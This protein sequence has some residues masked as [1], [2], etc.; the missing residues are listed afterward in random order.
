MKNYPD[1]Y[2]ESPRAFLRK[3]EEDIKGIEARLAK[4]D[5]LATGGIADL[6]TEYER[7]S[8]LV[9]QKAYGL[10]QVKDWQWTPDSGAKVANLYPLERLGDGRAFRWT[11]PQPVTEFIVP[12]VRDVPL[13][14]RIGFMKAFEPAMLDALQLTIDGVVIKHLVG[15]L[16][17]VA[18][19]A[20][21]AP[22]STQPTRIAVST[23][24]TASPGSDDARRLGIALFDIELAAATGEA[25]HE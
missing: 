25:S 17:I 24:A 11:G 6:L 1:L 19:V 23:G 2:A 8:L 22:L 15:D 3:L 7:L 21:R 9:E 18:T 5:K 12:I 13:R 4:L 16:Q 10:E 14:L 20:P